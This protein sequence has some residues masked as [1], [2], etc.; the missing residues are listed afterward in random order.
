MY[1]PIMIYPVVMLISVVSHLGKNPV[2][3]HLPTSNFVPKKSLYPRESGALKQDAQ[4]GQS[5]SLSLVS[6]L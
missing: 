2:D 4:F 1:K 5:K 6:L 3:I